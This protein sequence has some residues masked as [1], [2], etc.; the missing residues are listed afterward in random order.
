MVDHV[1]AEKR[2][3]IMAAVKS[4]NTKTEVL[5]RRLLHGAGFR[6]RLHRKDL[7]GRPDIVLPKYHAVVFIN[8]CFWHG[9]NCKR[10]GT[11][12]KTNTAFWKEKIENNKRRDI[13]NIQLLKSRNWRV[14]II[15]ECALT[16]G[17]RQEPRDILEGVSNWLRSDKKHMEISGRTRR[18]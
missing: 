11:L 9:H 10:S 1:I 16:R 12:P 4:K 2:S 5:V 7:P 14:C 18:R 3:Q 15:W 17:S 13:N 6:Y 8:G